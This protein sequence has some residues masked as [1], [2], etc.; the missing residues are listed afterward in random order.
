MRIPFFTPIFIF[1]AI[2]CTPLPSLIAEPDISVKSDIDQAFITIGDRINFRLTVVHE[3]GVRVLTYNAGEALRDFEIKEVQDF[4]F[5]EGGAIHEGKNY[6]ITNYELGEYVIHP[7]T[8]DYRTETGEV[9]SIDSN[10]LYV[11]VQSIDEG[12]DPDADI[13]GVKGVLKLMGTP[14]LWW[15]L[16]AIALGIGAIATWRTFFA[17]KIADGADFASTLSPHEEAYKAL[18]TL[19]HSDLLRNNQYKLYFF[20][21]SEILRRYFERRYEVPALESTT[22]EVMLALKE[23]VDLEN[24]KLIQEIL[25]FCDFVKFAKYIPS[26]PEVL[27]HNKRALE[28]IDRTKLEVP[29]MSSE[30]DERDERR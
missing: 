17:K 24:G 5:K 7:I 9:K 25:D 6:V 18:Y 22:F 4:L 8:V 19:K 29:V 23:K 2:F 20:Q 28:V 27:N 30:N 1:F 14:W 3:P 10:G 15:I 16:I 26:V 12:K 21:M 11:S 13:R